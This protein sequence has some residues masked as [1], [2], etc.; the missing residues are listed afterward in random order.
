MWTAWVRGV[1]Y[2]VALAFMMWILTQMLDPILAM[3]MSGPHSSDPAV[4][5]VGGYFQALTLD[6]L[7]LLAGLAVAIYILG[8]A[9]VE[10][11]LG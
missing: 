1:V 2:L 6:N 3:A 10:R 9:A 7:T 4:E 5:R 8:R 11:Q